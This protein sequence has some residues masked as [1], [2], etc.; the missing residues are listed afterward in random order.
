[1]S[2]HVADG[3]RIR[4]L[5]RARCLTQ[6]ELG[7]RVGA[8][9]PVI[10]LIEN[11]CVARPECLAGLAAFFGLSIW[12][13]LVLPAPLPEPGPASTAPAGGPPLWTVAEA[14]AVLGVHRLAIYQMIRA[15]EL[16]ARRAGRSWRIPAK[17][18]RACLA[19]RAP[20]PVPACRPALGLRGVDGDWLRELREARGWTQL[21]LARRARLS[22]SAVSSLET[23]HHTSGTSAIP[24]LARAL[25]VAPADLEDRRPGQRPRRRPGPA[26]PGA[27]A[28][29]PPP[30]QAEGARL[31]ELRAQRGLTQEELARRAGLTRPFLSTLER[32]HRWRPAVIPDLARALGVTPAKLAVPAPGSGGQLRRLSPPARSSR[33]GQERLPVPGSSLAAALR[34]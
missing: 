32:G 30:W 4:E 11:G 14:A 24:D 26:H 12:D 18:V 21:E 22:L 19:G 1:V 8:G 20:D 7:A 3:R 6:K 29:V 33:A 15:G 25:G 31:K 10:S 16:K 13:L 27:T 17:S 34:H 23:G 9:Q 2:G 5:R 28:S